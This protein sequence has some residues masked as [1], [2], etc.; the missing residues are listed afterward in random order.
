MKRFKA[1]LHVHTALSPCAEKEMTPPAIVAEARSKGLAMIAICDHNTAGNT[2]ATQTAAGEALAVIA[3]MEVTTAED[4]HVLGLFPDA[5]TAVAAAEVVQ[6]TLPASSDAEGKFGQQL[7]LGPDGR[8]LGTEP[9]MLAA[10]SRLNLG[11]TIALIKRHRG[12]AVAA[13]VNRPS[14][15]V[16]SQL[17]LF[18]DDADFD[19]VE[20]FVRPRGPK[21][22][23]RESGWGRPMLRSSDAHFLYDVGSGFTELEL[24]AATFAEL[25]LALR[26]SGG[27]RVLHA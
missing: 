26:G 25:S 10:S 13:H 5:A 6:S 24:A 2:A 21:S 9:K 27:R 14:F 16:L 7:L 1:D 11:Q 23:V 12:L 22:A 19:A 8:L 20:L 4:I 3:G 18:P 17:G 15:S